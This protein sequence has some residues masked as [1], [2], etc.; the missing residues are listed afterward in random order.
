MKKFV[1]FLCIL[2]GEI[3]SLLEE[4]LNSGG[5]GGHGPPIP[6]EASHVFLRLFR[7]EETALSIARPVLGVSSAKWS[8]PSKR[9]VC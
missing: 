9:L 4:F 3:N 6:N 1:S 8:S 7:I 5:G 2:V